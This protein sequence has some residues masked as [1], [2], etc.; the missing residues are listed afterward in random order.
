MRRLAGLT[1][2]A[3][4]VGAIATS[5][6]SVAASPPPLLYVMA[7]GTNQAT[8]VPIDTMTDQAE[9]PVPLGR[10]RLMDAALS[11]NG[12]ALDVLGEGPGRQGVADSAS[13]PRPGTVVSISTGTDAVRRRVAVSADP[14]SIAYSP[15]GATAYVTS[16]VTADLEGYV[17]PS[18]VTPLVN[19]TSATRAPIPVDV[20]PEKIAVSPNG[21]RVYLLTFAAT[22]GG[23]DGID[24]LAEPGARAITRIP[25]DAS[26][27]VFTPNS[28][29]AYALAFTP[30]TGTAIVPIHVS[31]GRPGPSVT[32]GGSVPVDLAMSPNGRTLWVLATPDAGVNPDPSA[33]V[34]LTPIDVATNAVGPPIDVTTVGADSGAGWDVTLSA[35]G[36]AAYV[37]EG[38]SAQGAGTLFPVDLRNARVAPGVAVGVSAQSMALSPGGAVLYV[39]DTGEPSGAPTG[40]VV[41]VD[42]AADRAE[43]P[44]ALPSYAT[45]L[46][47]SR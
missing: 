2:A 8:V 41:P 47:M 9:K 14:W 5:I 4:V 34:T 31:T 17:A 22:D 27:V 15:N 33:P 30:S 23:P 37:L 10:L 12:T 26:Q 28:R 36:Q 7:T 13:Q 16:G 32:I 42:L 18:L 39:L 20:N 43:A 25:V 6:P 44:I 35:N 45:M 3:A 1:L 11:P 19:A 46:V 21:D 38:G 40:A 29:T 24:V